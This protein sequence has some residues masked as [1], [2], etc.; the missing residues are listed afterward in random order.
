MG[1]E[2]RWND[3]KGLCCS[4]DSIEEVV[5]CICSMTAGK[6]KIYIYQFNSDNQPLELVKIIEIT[7]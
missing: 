4:S 1:F 7:D 3:N 6:G 5:S 2:A